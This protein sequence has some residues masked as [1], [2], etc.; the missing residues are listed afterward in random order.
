MQIIN[1]KEELELFLTKQSK[2]EQTDILYF[3][4]QKIWMN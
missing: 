2:K 3:N 4:F 1:F